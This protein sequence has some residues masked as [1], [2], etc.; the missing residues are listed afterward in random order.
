MVSALVSLPGSRVRTAGARAMATKRLSV[1]LA[2]CWCFW[3]KT[4]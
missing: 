2:G 4:V 3:K 1:R